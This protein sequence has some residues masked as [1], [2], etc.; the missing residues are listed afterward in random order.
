[1]TF[2]I[3]FRLPDEIVGKNVSATNALSGQH[4]VSSQ[5][6]ERGKRILVIQ[7]SRHIHSAQTTL[8][9]T[10][11]RGDSMRVDIVPTQSSIH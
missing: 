10:G 7:R 4:E 11:V 1:M 3:S 5:L 6:C 9:L 8:L 2:D